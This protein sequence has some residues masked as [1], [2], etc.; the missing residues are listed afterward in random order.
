[1]SNLH[2]MSIFEDLIEELKEENLIEETVI[3]FHREKNAVDANALPQ[4]PLL[5]NQ[6]AA[7]LRPNF[8]AEEIVADG[9]PIVL[10]NTDFLFSPSEAEESK[11]YSPVE[12]TKIFVSEKEYFRKRAVD[13]VM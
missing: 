8:P 4:M 9:G 13:E 10:E 3:E 5:L 7:A 1:M 11:K 12:K 6:E 2:T